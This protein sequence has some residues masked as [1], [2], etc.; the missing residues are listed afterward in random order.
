MKF[1]RRNKSVVI[2]TVFA[3]LLWKAAAFTFAYFAQGILPFVPNYTPFISEYAYKYPYLVGVWGNFDGM[4]YLSIARHGY[5][6]LKQAFFPLY[7]I[8]IWLIHKM[9]SLTYVYSALFLSH[10]FF[11]LTLPFLYFLTKKDEQQDWFLFLAILLFFPTSFFYGAIYNDA[12]FFFLATSSVFFSRNQK[13]FLAS[14]FA[15]IAT[16]CRLNGLALAVFI[17]VEF[18]TATTSTEESWKFRNLLNIFQ[19]KIRSVELWRSGILWIFLIPLSFVSYL[20]Y[21]QYRFGDWTSLFSSMSIWKQSSLTFPAVV[22]WRYIKILLINAPNSPNFWV[23]ALELLTV[24]FYCHVLLVSIKKIRLSY[25]IFIFTSILIP[26]VTG[27]F[28]GMPRYAL[29]LYPFFLA[30]TFLL[31]T[32]RMWVKILYFAIS[33][34]IFFFIIT[35]FSR[36]YFVS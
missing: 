4:H 33:A 19:E 31:S 20:A 3:L 11:L 16:L 29:H 10:F 1:L 21:I 23:A 25:W 15:G 34:C 22:I 17:G 35:L 28:Q 6:P 5:E 24:V 14:F 13:W 12:L 8:C 36:G 32:Q 2:K 26:W 9:T 30:C 7:P 27:T 18:L